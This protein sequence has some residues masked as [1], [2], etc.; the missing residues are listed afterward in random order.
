VANIKRKHSVPILQLKLLGP[1]VRRGR[2]SVPD[3]IRLCQEAQNVVNKQA[4][5]LEGKK[6][7][8]PGPTSGMIQHECTLELV[9]IKSNCTTLQFDLAKPQIPFQFTEEF[10]AKV[11][12]EVATTIRSLGKRS[13]GAIDPGL[14][15]SV[16]G[17]SG[18]A[19]TRGI[20]SIRWI[21]GR[22]DGRRRASSVPIT[23][24]V[25]ERAA[26]RLSLPQKIIVRIDGILDMA[27]FK[28]KERRCRIDPPIG[29]SIMCAFGAERENEIYRLLRRPVRVK[30]VAIL[31]PY[32]DRIETVQIDEISPLP[33]LALGEG[34]FFAKTSI[35]ELAEMQHVKPL[36]DPS[37]LSGGIPDDEDVDEFL[38]AIYGARK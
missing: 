12:A 29:A 6:T 18:V 30:G 4:E 19:E 10:G 11:V 28:P 22:R 2:V 26:A 16:Y 17:L 20:S 38:E 34:N 27:D 33:S 5:A 21:T 37:V 13:Q 3:L 31:Q 7:I 14:L 9:G 1:G 24:T 36:K 32:T 15:L 8:H 25:R 23:K 35:G